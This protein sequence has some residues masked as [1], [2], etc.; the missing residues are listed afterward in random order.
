MPLCG[1]CCTPDNADVRRH[2]S[3]R[4][5]RPCNIRTV[6]DYDSIDDWSPRL[7]Q[8]LTEVVPP[9]ARQA[10]VTSKP[11]FIEDALET[12][13][14]HARR[15]MVVQRVLTWI[16]EHG[17]TA[18][19]GSRLS[20]AEAQSVRTTGLKPLMP[21]QR[22]VRIERALSR[23]PQWAAKA[24]LLDQT[25][26]AHSGTGRS[27]RRE[28][29]VHLTL[30]RAGLTDGFNHYLTHG[31]EFDQQVAHELLGQAGVDLLAI[32]GAPTLVTLS[33]P[34]HSALTGAHRYFSPEEMIQRSE[35]PNLVR[36]FLEAWSFKLANP[37][38]QTSQRKL[39]CGICFH[40]SV[41]SEWIVSVQESPT[42]VRPPP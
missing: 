12:L 19:H 8:A 30:S 34:G 6:L 40:E 1:L 37:T 29:Q 13:L 16:R 10:V 22:R 23:H 17:V 3:F 42:S 32:D 15:E 2:N 33:V 27:G 5:R 7:E 28:S 35:V 11:E 39:D 21:E 36:Q 18:Y 38:Y 26:R 25:I 4:V 41:P 24:G 9:E 31:S 14:R 20:P